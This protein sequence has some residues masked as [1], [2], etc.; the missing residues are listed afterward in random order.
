[1][2]GAWALRGHEFPHKDSVVEHYLAT[3]NYYAA[4]VDLSVAA[5]I[6]VHEL[7]HGIG[8]LF[9]WKVN[10]YDTT[11]TSLPV[12][13]LGHPDFLS[14]IYDVMPPPGTGLDNNNFMF[15]HTQ[16]CAYFSP[17]QLGIMHRAMHLGSIKRYTYPIA[18]THLYP[19]QINTRL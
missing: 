3:R 13:E 9:H 17:M 6:L 2:A 10:V 4:N 1:M 11:N 19:K 7:R 18:L 16:I 5:R 15:G 12:R 8:P 14:D